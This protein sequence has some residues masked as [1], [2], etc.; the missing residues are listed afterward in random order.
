MRF[1]SGSLSLWQVGSEAPL[2]IGGAQVFTS[3]YNFFVLFERLT[4]CTFPGV[5]FGLE[6]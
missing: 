2:D 6:S 3:A 1:V 4:Y 5:N